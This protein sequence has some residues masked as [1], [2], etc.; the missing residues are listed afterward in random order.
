MRRMPR[1]GIQWVVINMSIG[2]LLI[3]LA[4]VL[5]ITAGIHYFLWIRLARDPAWPAPVV[6]GM[7][8]ALAALAASIPLGIYTSRT[9]TR[10]A[11]TPFAW[12]AY[13]WMGVMFILFLTLLP[14]EL[15]RPARASA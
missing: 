12:V 5:S 2:R 4:V 6:R 15:V 13:V 3:F 7:G 14:M 8:F 9:L 1:R 10:D 11:A